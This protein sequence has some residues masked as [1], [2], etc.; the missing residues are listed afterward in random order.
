MTPLLDVSGLTRHFGGLIAVNDVA[1]EIAPGSV[2]GLIGPN[3][4][5]KTT[6]LNMVSGH[7]ASSS[8]WIRFERELITKTPVDVRA[9]LGIRRTFQNLKLFREMTVL[10]NIMVGMHGQTTCEIWH[11]LLR[12]PRQKA[13][14]AAIVEQAR[15]ALDFVGLLHLAGMPA[16]SLPY[17]SQRLVEIAR[18]IVAS[19][20]L[21]LL[22]EPA[23]GL[24]GAESKKM[25]G[26]IRAIRD[27]GV[28][29]L[30]VEHHMDVVM[31]ACDT[32]TVLNYGKRLANGTP[33]QIRE[34]PE[35]IK[36]YLG[37]GVKRRPKSEP[38]KAA[39][40]VHAAS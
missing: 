14:E 7:L 40:L 27:S 20:K 39:E 12:T 16:G 37:G 8:G 24:N 34:H 28:T 17:G 23:A 11:A 3:G 18:A 19:P 29:I 35:V 36:A 25:V 21:L 22:D 10:E 32:I 13:E 15:K 4:A 26:L 2:H 38:A 1:L 31:P 5:G 9:R 30:L 33:A 6:M